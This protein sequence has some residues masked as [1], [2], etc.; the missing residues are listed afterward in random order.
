MIKKALI[1]GVF[2]QDG[3]YLA[4]LLQAKN[5]EVH[6]ICRMPLSE[7]ARRIQGHLEGK[8][9]RPILHPCKL[10]QF[11]Q[12]QNLLR[13]L[14]PDEIYHLAATHYNSATPPEE[15]NRLD[16]ELYQ[17]NVLAALNLVHAVRIESPSTRLVLAGSC[18]M[19]DNTSQSPQDEKTPFA[20]KSVYGLSR[21]AGAELV[22]LFR[23]NYKLH[24]STAILYNH[25]SPRHDLTY[26]S[27]IIAHGVAQVK[28]GEREGFILGNLDSRRDWGYA[29]DY[30][31]AI[32][33]MAQQPAAGDYVI[34]TG[35]SQSVADFVQEAFAAVDIENW[36]DRVTVNHQIA[37]R[38]ETLLV[39]KPEKAFRKLDWRPTVSFAELAALMVNA[40]LSG[41]LD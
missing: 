28:K 2:G 29:K 41:R 10:T 23:E 32:W 31:R 6:G 1:T 36:R 27:Q 17:N 8:G 20:T 11:D 9:C 18:M 16:R 35:D 38:T 37:S 5:Y 25:E 26:V 15:R 34:A 21:I 24:L 3:S 33:L 19:F 13:S 7:N 14:R 39:G 30:A 22:K 12:I 4:E 40:A